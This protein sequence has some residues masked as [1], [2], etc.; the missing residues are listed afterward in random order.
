VGGSTGHEWAY[1]VENVAGVTAEM[2]S[3]GIASTYSMESV[4]NPA[5]A[6]G[7]KTV[8]YSAGGNDFEGL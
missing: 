4:L 7:Y 3:K 6:T 1:Q 8:W 5:I 2:S